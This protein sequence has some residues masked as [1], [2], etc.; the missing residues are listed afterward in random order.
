[1]TVVVCHSLGNDVVI[2]ILSDVNVLLVRIFVLCVFLSC[3][4]I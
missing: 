4:C 2:D 3:A 1:M